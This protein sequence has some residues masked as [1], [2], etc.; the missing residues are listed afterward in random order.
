MCT[1]SLI[2]AHASCFGDENSR[3]SNCIDNP[4]KFDS[5]KLFDFDPFKIKT[6]PVLPT[7]KR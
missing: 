5:F 7:P 3:P 2:K 1:A 6:A 4:I